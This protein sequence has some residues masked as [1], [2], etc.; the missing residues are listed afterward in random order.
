MICPIEGCNK[1]IRSYGDKYCN[2]HRLLIQ[3]G[4][5]IN[6]ICSMCKTEYVYLSKELNGFN[7]CVSCHGVRSWVKVKKHIYLNHS[8]TPT[9]FIELY[10]AQSGRC[11]LC[12]YRPEFE[13]TKR[14]KIQ[15]NIDHDHSCCETTRYETGSEARQRYSCGKCIRGLLCHPCNLMIGYYERCNGDL[16]IV[17]FDKYLAQQPFIFTN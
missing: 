10:E 12:H 1:E 6:R 7:D 17:E 9:Q 11:K 14:K 3:R 8:L 4:K 13:L 2:S 5:S 15:L 16:T